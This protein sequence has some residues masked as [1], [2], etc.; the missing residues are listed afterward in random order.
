[1]G[2]VGVLHTSYAESL[3]ELEVL[4]DRSLR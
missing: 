1:V 4:F 2:M 3:A